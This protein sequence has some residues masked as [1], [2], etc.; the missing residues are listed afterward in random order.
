MGS[1]EGFLGE[2]I[3]S[4]VTMILYFM[5]HGD[6]FYNAQG[7]AEGHHDSGLTVGAIDYAIK[8]AAV[9]KQAS[10]PP[11]LIFS[12]DLPRSYYTAMIVAEI[13]HLDGAKVRA[14]PFLREVNYGDYAGRRFDDFE[15]RYKQDMDALFPNGES[16]NFMRMRVMY[17]V[18]RHILVQE[19]SSILFVG[20][21]GSMRTL[22]AEYEGLVFEASFDSPLKKDIHRFE[23]DGGVFRRAGG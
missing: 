16:R 2:A 22:L 21:G 8:T 14:S 19:E 13:L 10:A 3:L 17:Y 9:L 12:S 11:A 1:V 5:R 18:T 7:R 6:S 20:H 15:P 4:E 23:F